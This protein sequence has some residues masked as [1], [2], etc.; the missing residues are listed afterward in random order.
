M[1]EWNW[2]WKEERW[3]RMCFSFS[4]FLSILLYVL[5]GNKM[6]SFF[7][8]L[9]LLCLWQYL[10]HDF[11]FLDYLFHLNHPASSYWVADILKISS[12]QIL[13]TLQ[14]YTK[15]H[16]GSI[17]SVQWFLFLPCGFSAINIL[18]Y[19]IWF[20]TSQTTLVNSKPYAHPWLAQYLYD[21]R[22]WH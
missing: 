5:I 6:H 12:P 22:P 1:Q 10:K 11:L 16:S 2:T 7:P 4:L 18:P 20:C 13:K 9:S 14:M 19:V 17:C 3:M 21:H 8:K 15:I